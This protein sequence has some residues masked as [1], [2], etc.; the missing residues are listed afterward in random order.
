MQMLRI[1]KTLQAKLYNDNLGSYAQKAKI[2]AIAGIC[3]L[4]KDDYIHSFW[5]AYSRYI[6][7]GSDYTVYDWI[8][9]DGFYID[10][11]E[12][13]RSEEGHRR[14]FVQTLVL[15]SGI[16]KKRYKELLD[17]FIFYWRYFREYHDIESLIQNI[18]DGHIDLSYIPAFHRKKL[19]NLCEDAIA[20]SRAFSE[21]VR[22][23]SKVFNFI[24]NSENILSGD[25]EDYVDNIYE[26]CGI[27]PFEILR[28]RDQLKNLYTRVLG[29]VTPIK[30][31]K[32]LKN[33]SPYTQ[34][35]LPNGQQT[36]VDEYKHFMYGEHQI[37]KSRFFCAPSFSCSV[38]YLLKI[39]SNRVY[40]EG[41]EVILK[42]ESKIITY[43]NGKKR[44]E[45]IRKFY[46][47][48]PTSGSTFVG[49]IF[50]IALHPA[51]SVDLITENGE[52][53]ETIDPL[54]GVIFSANVQYIF[55][56][57]TNQFHLVANIPELRLKS[58]DLAFK[59]I[60]FYVN[61]SDYPLFELELDQEG[62]GACS[63]CTVHL[64]APSKGELKFYAVHAVSMEPLVIRGSEV[65]YRIDL[66][67]TMLFSKSRGFKFD[68]IFKGSY[69]TFG[70]SEFIL[71]VDKL[72]KQE[73]IEL[74][75]FKFAEKGECGNYKVLLLQWEDRSKQCH[76]YVNNLF[77]GFS[78]CIDIDLS[79]LKRP[80]KRIDSISLGPSQ[81]ISL[82]NF[83]LIIY[84]IPPQNFQDTL[85]WKFLV[86][87]TLAVSYKFKNIGYI[88]RDKKALGILG[89]EILSLLEPI[90][91]E[92]TG[93]NAA[94]DINLFSDE[95]EFANIKLYVFPD[96]KAFFPN[97]FKE[98]EEVI[99]GIKLDESSELINVHLKDRK[100][101]SKA[102]L[103]LQFSEGKWQLLQNE[104]KGTFESQKP[105]TLVEVSFR[106][107]IFGWR[108]AN[109]VSHTSE[110][111]RN[112]LQREVQY[113]EL[114]GIFDKIGPPFVSINGEEF[115]LIYGK[116]ENK[117]II[118]LGQLIPKIRN[119]ENDVTINCREE[120]I[121]FAIKFDTNI[122]HVEI[123]DHLI[124]EC[125][126]GACSFIGPVGAGLLFSVY[127]DDTKKDE[128]MTYLISC[129]GTE[130]NDFLLTFD[131]KKNKVQKCSSYLVKLMLLADINNKS[132]GNE[133][134]EPWF[135]QAESSIEIEDYEYLKKIAVTSFK[136]KRYFEAEKFML[137]ASKFAPKSEHTWIQ[138]FI[139][140]IKYHILNCQIENI[141]TQIAYTM[142]KEYKINLIN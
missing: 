24:E 88:M 81:S 4:I 7:W 141:C 33:Y 85:S 95:T 107:R 78:D 134:G 82:I 67:S 86:N 139:I 94:I 133:Y 22:K 129:D 42:S 31:F 19:K 137:K 124:D 104:Y 34:I 48:S 74:L 14:E 109:K 72:V 127:T 9:E 62:I 28:D 39:D 100:D 119:F 138:G 12:L 80:V 108:L 132:L 37:G 122:Q 140:N 96:L 84:P 35:K 63:D 5:D 61:T 117:L 60:S 43:V 54:D 38:S 113:F 90:W 66:T 6:G 3:E 59:N 15:E 21:V 103:D 136:N 17:F 131:L 121:N 51:I 91:N 77:W 128:C 83:E 49:N 92:E 16:P 79:V 46:H 102:I 68:P 27:D 76:V 29:L 123:I 20:Y 50:Y 75:N 55:N 71:F 105:K 93:E 53:N 70:E 97:E 10:G 69:S 58:K 73:E 106:P 115:G 64:N 135:V 120:Q 44:P 13:I 118:P 18:V 23:L 142:N 65:Q 130:Y 40:K 98:G 112:L 101:R 2:V 25:I 32:I 116:E 87:S 89:N 11:I 47:K 41:N 52:V 8:W 57:R 99:V 45:L 36:A 1:H 26:G 126:T 125:I 114:I 111:L 30:L 110:V 56:N